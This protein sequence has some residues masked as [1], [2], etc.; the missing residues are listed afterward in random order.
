MRPVNTGLLE[1]KMQHIKR[2]VVF[3]SV[4]LFFLLMGGP[5]QAGETLS[6]LNQKAKKHFKAYKQYSKS[7]NTYMAACHL[8]DACV[9]KDSAHLLK[10]K[11]KFIKNLVPIVQSA[12]TKKLAKIAKLNGKENFVRAHRELLHLKRFLETLRM[13]AGWTLDNFEDDPFEVVGGQLLTAKE[14]AAQAFLRKG[15]SLIESEEYVAALE[16]LNKALT[17]KPSFPEASL[18]I[19]LS[20]YQIGEDMVERQEYRQAT[21]HYE[22]SHRATPNGYQD[23][24]D[25]ANAILYEMA[26]YFNR[27]GASRAAH[28]CI[29]RLRAID[30]NYKNSPG[31]ERTYFD[32]AKISVGFGQFENKTHTMVAGIAVGHYLFREIQDLL[33]NQSSPY[34]EL[35]N[36]AESADYYLEGAATQVHAQTEG[37][38]KE[39]KERKVNWTQTKSIKDANGKKKKITIPFSRMLIYDEYRLS[40]E[41]AMAGYVSLVKSGSNEFVFTEQLS[42]R[43]EE[44]ARWGDKVQFDGPV[45]RIPTEIRVLFDTH[46]RS[47]TPE[48]KMFYGV[49]DELAVSL[50]QQVLNHLDADPTPTDPAMLSLSFAPQME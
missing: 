42:K 33:K 26:L 19:A 34:L 5:I 48:S 17:Y 3:K 35:S 7:G 37:P 22:K 38:H 43:K 41:V 21:D 8:L 9:K 45:L 24:D 12:Y 31:L 50:A 29:Q 49:L 23:A 46:K 47:V 1:V 4:G 40:R 36:D 15:S 25:K 20:H 6:G 44:S 13:Q 2:S 39:R 27:K 16:E 14:G 10:S 11:K 18:K 30:A 32:A 28:Q